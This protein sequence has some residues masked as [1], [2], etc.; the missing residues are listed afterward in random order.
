[1]EIFNSITKQLTAVLKYFAPITISLTLIWI[2]D[3]KHDIFTIFLNR[4]FVLHNEVISLW[5]LLLILFIY[6]LFVYFLHRSIIH[7]IITR[8]ILYIYNKKFKTDYKEIDLATNRWIRRGDSSNSDQHNIQKTLD[9]FNASAHF[10]YCITWSSILLYYILTLTMPYQFT[11]Y[12]HEIMYITVNIL[13]FVIA[14]I[15]DFRSAYYDIK[16]FEK[17]QNVAQ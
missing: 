12:K 15:I 11:L 8:I 7:P 17:Y 10:F 6:G 3:D 9:E 14:V 5:F 13:I 16:N 1:M 4:Y 2:S